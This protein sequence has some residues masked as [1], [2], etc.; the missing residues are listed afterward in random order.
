MFSYY[1]SSTRLPADE[2]KLAAPAPGE[3]ARN[4]ADI[5]AREK[6]EKQAKEITINNPRDPKA[7]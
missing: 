2:A 4:L 1:R 5:K 7:D 3:P 6:G